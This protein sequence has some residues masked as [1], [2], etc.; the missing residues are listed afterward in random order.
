MSQSSRPSEHLFGLD[1][2]SSAIK[3]ARISSA[4][5]R[6][7]LDA[8]GVYPTPPG[9]FQEGRIKDMDTLAKSISHL[10]KE[11]KLPKK[12][13][14]MA[15]GKDSAMIQRFS[16]FNTPGSS[17]EEVISAQ[18]ETYFSH[19]IDG[20]NFD[21][22]V[23]KSSFSSENGPEVLTAVVKRDDI[24]QRMELARLTGLN[25]VILDVEAFALQNIH[26]TICR[27]D[28]DLPHLLVDMG[29]QGSFFSFVADKEPVMVRENMAGV[30]QILG[31]I[32]E[33]MHVDT[34]EARQI[35]KGIRVL[36]SPAEQT[37]LGQICRESINV[38]C[39][40]IQEQVRFFQD[41]NPQVRIQ[42]VLVSGGGAGV[43]KFRETLASVLEIPVSVFNPLQEIQTTGSTH[44]FPSAQE[45]SGYETAIA[46]GLALRTPEDFG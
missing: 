20:L 5:E 33:N 28:A 38:W 8:L 1:I 34:Q 12:N 13:A 9:A 26:E 39:M 17:L 14:V 4:Q 15:V 41:E 6:I 36:E 27:E 2:G 46:L 43:G 19:D 22:Q 7:H 21:F 37:M 3:L 29:E 40:E 44:F 25:L 16:S 35:L 42:K 23:M 18:A 10:F 31:Q 11:M 30:W 24:A 32:E 45:I